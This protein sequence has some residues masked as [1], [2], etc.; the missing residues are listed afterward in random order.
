M[1]SLGDPLVGHVLDG[2]YQIIQRLA[3]GGMATVY[4]AVDTRLTRT[5]AVKVMHVGLGDDAEFARKFDRE[6]RAAARLSHPNVVS[7]FDQG[8]D[9][10]RPYIVMEYVEGMTVRDVISREAPVSALRALDL[11]EPVLNALACAHDAGL[12]HRDVKPENVLISDRG[13]IKVA[14][15]GLAKAVTAQTSTATAGLLIGTVSYLPPELVISGKAGPRSDV[16]STGVVLFELLTGRK[17]HTGE[18]PIQV[19]YAHVHNDVPPPSEF[20]APGTIPP[21]LDALLACVTARDPDARPHDA[22]VM[23]MQVRRVR[24]ALKEGLHDDPELTQDLT[25]PLL[26]LQDRP[27]FGDDELA[28]VD[29]DPF[30]RAQGVDFEPTT[31]VTGPAADRPAGHASAQRVLTR[32]PVSPP[33]PSRVSALAGSRRRPA[34]TSPVG[35]DR[36]QDQHRRQRRNRWRG[37]I[38]LVLVLMLTVLAATAG[39]YLTKGRYTTAPALTA[40]TQDQAA[41]AARESSLN[42][43]FHQAFSETVAK[44]SVISTDPAAGSRIESGAT[45]TAVVSKGPERYAMPDLVGESRTDALAALKKQNLAVGKVS[46]TWDDTTAKDHVLRASQRAGARLKKLTPV[47][48]T[49]SRGPKPIDIVDYTGKSATDA[50]KALKKAGFTVKETTRHSGSVAAGLVISQSPDKGNGKKGDTIA[51][52]R[53]LGPV[54]VTVPNVRAMGLQAATRVMADRGFKVAKK[55]VS[56]NFLGVGFVAYT[57]PRSGTKAPKGSTVTLYYV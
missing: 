18:T 53:S 54:L 55:P 45:M 24:A 3:R 43:A 34:T 39:W 48:L 35:T 51:L 8:R 21:Y 30:S 25:T 2:R 6:A 37:W 17:P 31:T 29:P 20:A 50:Q 57:D 38:A 11:I 41:A 47:D 32:V 40:M 5:V 15:F 49:V 7:V 28:A 27:A 36:L 44:G 16:Y 26:G 52:V 12:V 46:E 9:N 14:D 33:S 56:Q 19:A 23:L 1:T 10:G 42:I 22:R 4:Q 13:Q